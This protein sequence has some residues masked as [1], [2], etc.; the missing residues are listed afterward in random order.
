[1]KAFTN[2]KFTKEKEKGKGVL[3]LDSNNNFFN[4]DF[5]AL[6]NDSSDH[7]E[8]SKDGSNAPKKS[9]W[10]RVMPSLSRND[11][12]RVRDYGDISVPSRIRVINDNTYDLFLGNGEERNG[13]KREEIWLNPELELKFSSISVELLQENQ[14]LY[15]RAN[16]ESV[17]PPDPMLRKN[18][19][20]AADYEEDY[21][22]VLIRLDD[23][24]N[25]DPQNGKRIAIARIIKITNGDKSEMTG[26][27]FYH[28]DFGLVPFTHWKYDVEIINR[29]TSSCPNLNGLVGKVF[30]N[31][32]RG[33]DV[34]AYYPIPP[35]NILQEYDMTEVGGYVY[36]KSEFRPA[37]AR[38][39]GLFPSVDNELKYNI[40]DDNDESEEEEKDEDDDGV[41]SKFNNR[42][43]ELGENFIKVQ[44]DLE[45]TQLPGD[46]L[47][48]MVS[49]R[50]LKVVHKYLDS[51]ANNSNLQGHRL[52]D[53][54]KII[55]RH[56]K[57]TDMP[58]QYSYDVKFENGLIREKV[59][60]LELWP[61]T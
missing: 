18:E 30:Q 2:V 28:D 39:Y 15:D 27:G 47:M 50:Q 53:K 8:E 31:C 46:D 54:A 56:N 4:E 60:A 22:H 1:M 24:G 14:E 11:I 40:S 6:G 33:Y 34:Q 26:P 41:E 3:Q 20:E 7:A 52:T 38:Q 45:T 21:R 37:H 9:S 57:A 25:K 35:L 49:E 59:S 61:C 29:P 19:N 32:K 16:N 12:V 42:L 51:R 55:K 13:V 58:Y 44:F 5:I 17:Y 36:T 23:Y 10:V 48:S 43:E